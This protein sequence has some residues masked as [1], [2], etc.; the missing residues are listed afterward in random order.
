MPSWLIRLRDIVW[1]SVL[2]VVC[3]VLAIALAIFVPGTLNA[4]IALTGAGITF[5]LLSQR[6]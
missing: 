4:V 3:V 5:G 2:A 1:V 6:V